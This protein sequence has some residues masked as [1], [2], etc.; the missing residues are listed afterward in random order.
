MLGDD[1]MLATTEAK[2]AFCL[3]SDDLRQLSFRSLGKGVGVGAPMRY[4]NT[5]DL[6]A[7]AIRKH[8]L[9]G[10]QQKQQSRLQRELKKR[11][12]QDDARREM[13]ELVRP[14]RPSEP[15]A[16]LRDGAANVTVAAEVFVFNPER[17]TAEPVIVPPDT[18][19]LRQTLLKHVKQQLVFTAERCPQP[20]CV[21]MP[22]IQPNVFAALGGQL[23]DATTRAFND[24]AACHTHRVHARDLFC[25]SKADLLRVFHRDGVGI[26]IDGE[27]Q[28]EYRPTSMVLT[29]RGDS[30][31][32]CDERTMWL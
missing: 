24:S 31:L 19:V 3:T 4:Y 8:G 9:L 16:A 11:Q 14:S 20:W 21:E 7:A 32:V 10:L 13:P 29:L 28:L 26:Q 15:T 22:G 6:R 30:E 1:N 17:T 25:C 18:A 2:L 5:A 12:R 27:I 23:A